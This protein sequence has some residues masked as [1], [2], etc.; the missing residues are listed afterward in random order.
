MAKTKINKQSLMLCHTVS[1]LVGD[2]MFDKKFAK[3]LPIEIRMFGKFIPMTLKYYCGKW[4]DDLKS[5]IARDDGV[6]I[7]KLRYRFFHLYEDELF[8]KKLMFKYQLPDW[9]KECYPKES[10]HMKHP[11]EDECG[12]Q[13]M[14]LRL[15]RQ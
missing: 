5:I 6:K 3:Q 13:L 10:Q 4:E 15:R 14:I 9:I 12:R 7:S 11:F 8:L 2:N 1:H